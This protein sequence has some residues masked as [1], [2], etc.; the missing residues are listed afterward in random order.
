MLLH[1]KIGEVS[2]CSHLQVK[3]LGQTYLQS[4][5]AQYYLVGMIV[6][7]MDKTIY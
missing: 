4:P 2:T 5:K 7:Y 1:P 6:L 3:D